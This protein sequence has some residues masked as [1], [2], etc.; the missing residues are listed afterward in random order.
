MRRVYLLI[1]AMFLVSIMI[2]GSTGGAVA[3]NGEQH[4]GS[5][6]SSSIVDSTWLGAAGIVL[7]L[8]LVYGLARHRESDVPSADL[9][10]IDDLPRQ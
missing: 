6:E 5:S 10:D 9:D 4:S 2:A 7:V 8:V 3:H 1:I